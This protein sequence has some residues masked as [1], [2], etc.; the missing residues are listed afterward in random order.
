MA[1]LWSPVT[2]NGDTLVSY[3]QSSG[4]YPRKPTRYTPVGLGFKGI[5]A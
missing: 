1:M 3:M 5:D 4:A 2:S